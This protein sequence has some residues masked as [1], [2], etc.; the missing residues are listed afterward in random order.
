MKNSWRGALCSALS[1]GLLA[2]P[3]AALPASAEETVEA[4][5]GSGVVINEAYVNGGSANAPFTHKFVELYNTTDAPVSLD[6]WSLQYRAAG[7][8]TAPTGV[9]ELSGSIPA[10]GYFLVQGGS[11]DSF[12]AALPAPDVTTGLNFSGTRGTIVLS[13]QPGAVDPLAVGSVVGAPGVVDLLGYGSSNTYETAAE[14]GPGGTTNPLSMNRSDFVDTDNNKVDF[15]ALDAVT[16]TNA[17]GDQAGSEPEPDPDPPTPGEVIP[18]AEIQGNGAASPY[19]GQTVTTRGVVTAA[20]PTGGFDGYYI[21]TAGTGGDLG[22]DHAA[23]DGIFIY[24]PETVE[25]VAVGDFVEVTGLAGEYFDLSQITVNAGGMTKPAE[26]AVAVKASSVAYPADDAGRE[27][28]EGMLVHPTG[29]FTVTDNYALNQYGEIALAVGDSPLVQPT[30]IAPPGTPENAAVA[31]DNAARGVKLDDGATTNFLNSANMDQPLPYLTPE[32]PVRVTSSATFTAPVVL[33]FRN[34][35]WKFQ[36]LTALTAANAADVQPAAFEGTRPEAPENVG[37]NVKIASFN[38]L[39]YFTTTGD[40]LTGCTYYEDRDGNP[41]TVRGGCD[42]RG[43]AN[44]ENLERQEAKI[45]AAINGL[46][47]DVVSLEEIEN[48]AKFGKDRDEALAT[49]TAALNEATPGVWDYVRSPADLPALENEDFIRTAFI[50]KRA[51]VETV[52]ESVILDDNEAFSNARKPLAQTFNVVDGDESTRFLV[53]ANH[54]KSKGSGTG[55]NADQG[56]GQGASNAD[57]IEQATALVAF[58]DRLKTEEGTD[59]VFLAGDFNSYS[60]EDPMQVLYNAGYVNQGAKT[61]GYSYVFSGQVGSLDHILASPAADATVSGVDVWNI[62]A[63]ESVALEYSRYNYNATNFYEPNQFRAS[64]HDPVIVGL[65]LVPEGTTTELNL[66]GINDFHGRI[67]ANTVKFAGTIEQLRAQYAEENSLF[68]SAGDNIGASLFASSV[69]QDKPTID[70]L[71]ALDLSASAVGNHEFDAGFEDLSGR[72]AELAEFPYLGANVYEKGTTTPALQEYEIVNVGGIDVAVIGVVTQE[73][74]SLVSPDGISTL[75]FGNPV[76]AVNRVAAQIEEQDL[77]DV[78]VAE[79]HEGA[80]DGVVEGSTIEEEVAAG[81]AFAEIV[82]ETTPLVDAIYTGHTHKQYAWDAPVPGSEGETRP[83]VQT[84]SYGEFIGHITLTVDNATGEVESYT[85]QNV[86]RTTT[87]DA[88]LVAQFPRVAEVKTIVDA[89][90]AEAE[91]IGSQPVGSVT[92]D[93]TT[94]FVNGNRDDRTSESTL[95]NLVAESMRASLSAAERG[96]AEIGVVNPGGLRNE[97]YYGEDGVITYAEANAVLPFVNNLWTITLTGEQFKTML[98]QQWQPEGSS[99][100]FLALGLS[101]N[102]TY[103][104]N[105]DLA[106][107]SRITSVTIDGAPLDPARDYRIGTVSF[108]AQ[109]GDNFTVFREGT[110]V[111]DS[112]LVDRDAWIN[113]IQE[114]SPLSP[115]FDRRGVIVRN[116]PAE[117]EAGAEVSF[118]V[119]KLDLTSLGSPANTTLTATYINDG[120]VSTELGTT[121]VSGGAAEVTVTVPETAVGDGRIVLVAEESGTTVTLY[122]TAESAP[123]P[124]NCVPPTKPTRW[125]DFFGWIRYGYELIEYLKCLIGRP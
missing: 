84:G 57:R 22:S 48:S 31:A 29:G 83:I 11:N 74:P 114:N 24:S 86:A 19:A 59:K 85:A 15:T 43:A 99:R 66:M 53:I 30:E 1:V 95:G 63:V 6:G 68:L 72:V 125:W 116:A 47:A 71:N 119:A 2:S 26:A 4:Q 33:D 27:A 7:T 17:A 81:G 38:V 34:S 45:V 55:E 101:D 40:Q 108:L 113:Y 61:D 117:V 62:N 13:N 20:Y 98:E 94:A 67:D 39:N 93:I 118:S 56:D 23:S 70:V 91:V 102:V 16:P 92:A 76:E 90:L 121:P 124:P 3:V 79:F 103:T 89:A 111:R 120:G 8:V 41:I 36:P 5:A 51:A 10:N 49:L 78:I 107:G 106:A 105:P 112:G 100:S 25:S 54:F 82:T 123:E 64:D 9:A 37:G 65:N 32:E 73:T 60:A 14:E 109:G 69:A 35:S 58:A 28:L 122:V 104:Y 77:A 75:D 50:Y 97:L 42:A 87:D 21:Q 44:A 18:I 12:G 96:G 110:D 52:G 46:D 80:G 115:S 88:T